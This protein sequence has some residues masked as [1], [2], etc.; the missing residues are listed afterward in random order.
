MEDLRCMSLFFHF[1]IL[2]A[3]IFGGEGTTGYT[4]ASMEECTSGLDKV[5]TKEGYI[6]VSK[7]YQN[8]FSDRLEVSKN[9]VILISR[10]EYE[11]NTDE[12]EE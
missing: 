6:E 9:K 10:D 8:L 11:E 12:D 2:D 1:K 5:T 3:E 7:I 4:R